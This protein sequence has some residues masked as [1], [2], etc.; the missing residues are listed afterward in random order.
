MS[1]LQ[2]LKEINKQLITFAT[3]IKRVE[4]VLIGDEFNPKGLI[5][6]VEEMREE[7][8][9]TKDYI[10][11]QKTGWSLGKW[12]VGTSLGAFLL[13]QIGELQHVIRQI[14]K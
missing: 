3:T 5:H 10:I 4:V 7:I 11:Q 8:K 14:F 13:S 1:E 12:I 9:E 2:E 6:A